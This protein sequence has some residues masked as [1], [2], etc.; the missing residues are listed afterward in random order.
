MK[1]ELTFQDSRGRYR[2]RVFWTTDATLAAAQASIASLVALWN[3]LT[4]LAIVKATYF[5]D[6]ALAIA[7][8]AISNIDEGVSVPVVTDAGVGRDFNL[9]DVPDAKTPDG[10]LSVTDAD[11]IAL[12]ASFETGGVFRLNPTHP[13]YVVTYKTGI[14]DK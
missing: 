7:G 12:M 4:D 10:I 8:A 3:P 5:V 1:V 2:R 13:E 14:L 9:P 11:L 6:E